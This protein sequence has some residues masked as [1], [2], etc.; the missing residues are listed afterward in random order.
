MVHR[1]G[2]ALVGQGGKQVVQTLWQGAR[3]V[4]L[5]QVAVGVHRVA[6]QRKFQIGRNIH[7]HQAGALLL[8]LTAQ[9]H[10]VCTGHVHVQKRQLIQLQP[11]RCK[12]LGCAGADGGVHLHAAGGKVDGD[13][14]CH[15]RAERR[16]VVTDQDMHGRFLS[17][18][19]GP[20]Y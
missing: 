17:A 10:A 19:K 1:Q 4:P 6:F 13:I 5:E 18:A 15:A 16:I 8:E 11:R 12:H 2:L 7:Q 9:H 14:F 20:S 3:N